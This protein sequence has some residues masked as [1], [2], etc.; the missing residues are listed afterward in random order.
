MYFKKQNKTMKKKHKINYEDILKLKGE[1]F[2][3][4]FFGDMLGFDVKNPLSKNNLCHAMN[5]S[6]IYAFISRIKN[7][8]LEK[9][10]D[11]EKKSRII[12]EL[13]SLCIAKE[14]TS[15]LLTSIEL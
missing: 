13:I 3:K 12:I 8:D 1:A 2:F 15:Q 11:E 5:T 6:L 7:I 14:I 10:S 4:A 9:L